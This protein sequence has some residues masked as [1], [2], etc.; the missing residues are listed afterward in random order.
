M[1]LI[2]VVVVSMSNAH[3]QSAGMYGHLIL[4]AARRMVLN[5]GAAPGYCASAPIK[6]PSMITLLMF[7]CIGSHGE[8]EEE[9][10]EAAECPEGAE[11][12]ALHH[13]TLRRHASLLE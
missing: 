11:G 8:G 3:E 12:Q 10:G 1:D 2:R 9:E 7:H 4:S 13:P 6:G 5:H